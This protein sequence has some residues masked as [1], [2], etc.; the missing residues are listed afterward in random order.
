M[1]TQY[2]CIYICVYLIFMINLR[3]SVCKYGFINKHPQKSE[4]C[5]FKL[6]YAQ[7]V[8]FLVMEILLIYF[9]SS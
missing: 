2:L 8:I 9:I 4:N 6:R 5:A 7:N 3:L 1:C